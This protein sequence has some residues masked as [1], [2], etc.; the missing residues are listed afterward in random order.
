MNLTNIVQMLIL[1]AHAR[2]VFPTINI[3]A[4][5]IC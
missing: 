5:F 1:M 2:I 4:H 3:I